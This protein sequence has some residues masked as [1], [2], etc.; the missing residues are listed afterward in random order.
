MCV[1]LDVCVCCPQWCSCSCVCSCLHGAQSLV[2]Y[3]NFPTVFLIR[4]VMADSRKAEHYIDPWDNYFTVIAGS[5][6]VCVFGVCARVLYLFQYE[7][8][9]MWKCVVFCKII[10]LWPAS[11]VAVSSC[12]F[13]WFYCL[14][15]LSVSFVI[16]QFQL[17]CTWTRPI[18]DPDSHTGTHR[19]LPLALGCL[20]AEKN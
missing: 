17:G 8:Q 6:C 20:W 11:T 1:A 19:S 16:N 2:H 13:H 5:P 14:K 7:T 10:E 18:N 4:A 12:L 15:L 3:V 9:T